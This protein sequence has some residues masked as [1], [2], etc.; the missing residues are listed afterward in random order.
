MESG[1]VCCCWSSKKWDSPQIQRPWDLF[2]PVC[3][4]FA[5][6]YNVTT[7]IFSATSFASVDCIDSCLLLKPE[8]EK[9][10]SW[11]SYPSDFSSS[12]FSQLSL[13]SASE[14]WN[15]LDLIDVPLQIVLRRWA[16]LYILTRGHF[17]SCCVFPAGHCCSISPLVPAVRALVIPLPS[18]L[19]NCSFLSV[20]MLLFS[21]DQELAQKQVFCF[22]LLP[23][24]FSERNHW[25]SQPFTRW[26][27]SWCST[28]I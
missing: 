2:P 16:D 10:P 4:P 17:N 1:P 20:V 24:I 3:T 22:F 5:F 18:S 19:L 28:G 15:N 7:F 23:S 21:S 8:S 12:C 27:S 11:I 14:C 13:F 26:P 25:K 9:F 6:H